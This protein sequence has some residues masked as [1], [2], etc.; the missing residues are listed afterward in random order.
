MEFPLEPKHIA[1]GSYL[2]GSRSPSESAAKASR[3]EEAP[4]ARVVADHIRLY[5]GAKH[6]LQQAKGLAPVV[7]L[8]PCA[9]GRVVADRVWLSRERHI[10]GIKLK[11]CSH[12]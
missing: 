2:S 4:R 10:S 3:S 8:L 7:A 11:A 6:L 5:L 1:S 9:D 12:C